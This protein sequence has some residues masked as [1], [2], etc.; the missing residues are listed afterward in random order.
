M[1]GGRAARAATRYPAIDPVSAMSDPTLSTAMAPALEAAPSWASHLECPKSGATAPLEA[2]AGLS[3]AGA[4]WL[5]RYRL[6]RH[7][8]EPWRRALAARPRGL[9]R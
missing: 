3:P 9:W 2:P 4:P 8:G 7:A 1:V 5:V 6:E